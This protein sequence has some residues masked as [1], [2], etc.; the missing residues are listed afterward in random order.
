MNEIKSIL[1]WI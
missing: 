1:P